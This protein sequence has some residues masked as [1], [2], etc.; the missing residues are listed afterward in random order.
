[1]AEPAKEKRV[2][3]NKK[4]K[5]WKHKK[6]HTREQKKQILATNVNITEAALK[7]KLK[8]KYFK[9]D[10]KG[11]YKKIVSDFQKTSIANK[12]YYYNSV[13]YRQQVF[14]DACG[15]HRAR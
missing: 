3:K 14:Y 5:F 15:N 6:K 13:I 11:H 1:M 12:L 2:R 8:I 7:K 10:K 4:K 9:C